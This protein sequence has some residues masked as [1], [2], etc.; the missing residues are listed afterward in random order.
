MSKPTLQV[1]AHA[2]AFFISHAARC[3]DVSNIRILQ[4]AD[5]LIIQYDLSAPTGKNFSMQPLIHVRDGG[6]I[7]PQT[8][9]G[10]LTGVAAGKNHVIT[11]TVLEDVPE[12]TGFIAAEVRAVELSDAV[13]RDRSHR[14]DLAGP[15]NFLLSFILPGLGD[16]FVNDPGKEVKVK[17]EYIMCGYVTS[18]VLAY[19]CHRQSNE[20]YKAYQKSVQQHE[21]NS[22]YDL[23]GYYSDNARLFAFTAGAIWLADVV[24]VAVKGSM[25]RKNLSFAR[26]G[27]ELRADVVAGHPSLALVWT[28]D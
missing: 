11:W 19:Y 20:Y 7:I 9:S 21:M 12:L 5:R 24:R 28:L 3:Q 2:I 23:A 1:M 6:V 8:L 13:G 15:S 27:V 10:D 14:R 22:N 26:K 18:A 4:E 25:N 16:V 17:P